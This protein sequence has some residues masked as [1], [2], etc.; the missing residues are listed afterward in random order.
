M[1]RIEPTGPLRAVVAAPGSK[2]YTQRALIMAA[3][4]GGR[5]VLRNALD[6]EDSVRLVQALRSLGTGIRWE[7]E[8]LVVTGT[9]GMLTPP[10]SALFLGNN[11]TAM[12]LLTSVVALGNGTF[13][14]T[15]DRRLCE[16]PVGPLREALVALGVD[17]A[18]DGDRGCPPVTVRGRGLPGGR[19]VLK[20][21]D[22]SQY[23]SSLLISAP[24]ASADVTVV[25]EGHV[26]SLPYVDVTVEAMRQFGVEVRRDD[27]RT[28]V[29]PHGQHYAGRT[30][31][32]EGDVSSASYFFLAA[33]VTRGAVR[34]GR[35]NPHTRQGDIG[36]LDILEELGC[37]VRRGENEVEVAGGDLAVGDRVFDL[38]DMP[39][40]VPTLAVLAALRP[41]RTAITGVA[42]LRVKESNRLAA[43]AA[44]LRKT[45]ISAEERPDG[46]V[47]EGGRPR[48]AEIETYNDHRIAMSFAVLGLAVPGMAIRNERCV[49]K[50]FPR[51]WELMEGLN[52]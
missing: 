43:L 41:G 42:H 31:Q 5:S 45:G 44:E 9:G 51:F 46:L 49:A 2:S 4:A 29:V 47:I 32:V 13:T 15:G 10:G 3:L 17:I 27:G 14:L 37:T 6:A 26:P 33:A 38:T 40:M 48:G 50:S 35:I 18:T 34:V 7:G 39:D 23:V 24:Y 28:F 16:R 11:G 22:S 20:D 12:R 36:L 19:V 25:L 21:L 1:K 30:Y 8:D 52:A